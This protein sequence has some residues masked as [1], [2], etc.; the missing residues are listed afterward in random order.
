MNYPFLTGKKIDLRPFISADI[1]MITKGENDPRVR[2]TLFLA[3]PIG[4][5]QVTM[6]IKGQLESRE[7]ILLTIVDKKSGMGIGQTAFFRIDFVSRAAIFYLAILDPACWNQ[8]FGREATRLMVEY[9]FTTLNLNRIQLHV[10]ADNQPAIHIYQ[11]IGFRQEGLL[12]QAMY[13]NGRYCN[14]W[15]MGI[16]RADWEQMRSAETNDPEQSNP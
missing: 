7:T 3:L 10:F 11:Q 8:G 9:A 16:L 4:I 13:H 5:D 12:R 2:E 14:F 15:V 1:E 6:R